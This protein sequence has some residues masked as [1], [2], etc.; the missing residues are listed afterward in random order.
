MGCVK[1]TLSHALTL[2]IVHSTGR[3]A[4]LASP[5]GMSKRGEFVRAGGRWGFRFL[6]LL[7]TISCTW[8]KYTWIMTMNMGVEKHSPWRGMICQLP[9][10][11]HEVTSGSQTN[12]YFKALN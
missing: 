12:G 3:R 4:Q 8:L 6:L 11:T 9:L 7:W 10:V 2:R 5:L 1:V